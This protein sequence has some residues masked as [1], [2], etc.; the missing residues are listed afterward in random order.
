MDSINNSKGKLFFLYGLGGTGKTYIYRTRIV[1]L[2]SER[3]IVLPVVTS[4]IAA[5]LFPGGRTAHSRFKIPIDLH[6]NSMCDIKPKTMLAE[7]IQEAD[8]LIWDEAPMAHRHIFEALDRTLRDIMSM[9]DF[10]AEHKQFGGKTVFLGGDFRQILPFIPKGSRQ[11]TVLATL[12]R[13]TMW[14]NYNICTLTRNMRVNQDEK[15]FAKWILQV[16]DGEP[17]IVSSQKED[18]LDNENIEIDEALLLPQGENP[19]K[20]IQKATFPDLE[21]NIKIVNT[22][23]TVQS[24]HQEMKRSMS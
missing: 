10:M 2:R 15:E 16:G 23:E 18:S 6:E 5:T 9:N 7:L 13:S 17:K 14:S 12:N 19:M 21:N 1:Q 8:L 3:R 24:S 11:D 22:C 20:E 4:G